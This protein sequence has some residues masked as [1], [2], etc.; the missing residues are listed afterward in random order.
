MNE[1]DVVMMIPKVHAEITKTTKE[2]EKT[3]G[4]KWS[5]E[6]DF[7][8]MQVQYVY[9]KLNETNIDRLV[10]KVVHENAEQIPVDQRTGQAKELIKEKEEKKKGK[11]EQS[12]KQ[13]ADKEE[14][15]EAFVVKRVSLKG[16]T[17]IAVK[18]KHIHL[19][20]PIVLAETNVDPE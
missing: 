6:T 10:A 1:K 8:D 3:K 20:P 5:M 18:A 7:H 15:P 9:L 17:V 2:I 11:S 16:R 4:H 12:A 19:V 13:V 14:A